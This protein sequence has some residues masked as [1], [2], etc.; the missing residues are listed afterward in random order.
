M[1][2]SLDEAWSLLADEGVHR[3]RLAPLSFLFD[4]VETLVELDVEAVEEA[5]RHG[6]EVA[7]RMPL[8]AGTDELVRLV[9]T[10]ARAA[11]LPLEEGLL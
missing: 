3:V 4:H 9:A 2:P 11:P 8:F 1:G 6:I 5:S 7:G 10:A